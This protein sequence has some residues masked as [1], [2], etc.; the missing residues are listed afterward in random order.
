MQI[1][2][3]ATPEGTSLKLSG[4][5]DTGA[6][7]ELD[8]RIETLVPEVQSNLK[9]DLTDLSYLNSTGIRS[10]LRLDKLLK[11]KGLSFVFKGASPPLFRIF[12][13]CGL[14]TY[15]R[16]VEPD[17]AALQMTYPVKVFD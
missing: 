2:V 3:L 9:I 4:E 1:E 17:L 6:A 7:A 11:A 14:D 15:F 13:Y 16:F 10:F 8:A 5:L 12:R